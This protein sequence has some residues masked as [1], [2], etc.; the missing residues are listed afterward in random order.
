MASGDYQDPSGNLLQYGTNAPVFAALG[1]A[2][3]KDNW[4]STEKQ[5]RPRDLAKTG[6]KPPCDGGS[7]NVTNSFL[8]ALVATLST[9]P[10][11][12]S[13]ALGYTNA[14][15]VLSTCAS[16]GLLLK[17]SLPL[18]AI[19]RSYSRAT[20]TPGG[21]PVFGG[22]VIPA[23][24]HVWATHTAVAHGGGTPLVWYFALSLV[25]AGPLRPVD[26]VRTDLWPVLP[27]AQAVVVWDY[28]DPHG[29]A[30]LVGGGTAALASMEGWGHAYKIVAPVLG[31]GWAFLGETSKLVPVSVQRRFSLDTAADSGRGGGEGAAAAAAAAGATLVVTMHG[32]PGERCNISA[33]HSSGTVLSRSIVLD[34][35]GQGAA[36]FS[37][38]L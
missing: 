17:P 5:P 38:A 10:V 36:T 31:N 8:H 13:D 20:W 12:F 2:P 9:G 34:A 19:D 1:I 11:G 37:A 3:S 33:W 15:L 7:R 28:A 16:D 22:A 25:E 29:T 24:A 32:A 21:S 30:R 4:W 18:A 23:D 26:L 14:T 6:G 27:A 35:D